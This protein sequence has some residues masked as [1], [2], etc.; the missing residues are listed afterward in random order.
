MNSLPRI[1]PGKL[2]KVLLA[3]GFIARS[4]RGSH[5]VYKHADG[6]RTVIPAHNRPLKVGTLRAILKQYNLTVEGFTKLA[7]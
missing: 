6:R 4:G 5:V 7:E 1:K 2:E 3:Q